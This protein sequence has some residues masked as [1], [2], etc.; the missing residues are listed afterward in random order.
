[1]SEAIAWRLYIKIFFQ[2]FPNIHRERFKSQVFNLQHCFKKKIR[3]QVFSKDFQ[4][5]REHLLYRTSP[6]IMIK[7]KFGFIYWWK[8]TTSLKLLKSYSFCLD[9]SRNFR[10]ICSSEQ[11]Q[12]T[13]SKNFSY[14]VSLKE[15]YVT[16]FQI[17]I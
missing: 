1:M 13:S 6:N 12:V 9:S 14:L 10:N 15:C 7:Y 16:S 3:K 17:C 2:S 11:L 8:T 5:F 4:N